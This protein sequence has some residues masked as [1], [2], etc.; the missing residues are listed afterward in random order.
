MPRLLYKAYNPLAP[1]TST[2]SIK[3]TEVGSG[4]S[5]QEYFQGT[6]DF[7]SSN[8]WVTLDLIYMK[9]SLLISKGW[10]SFVLKDISQ[11]NRH[12][13][14][15]LTYGYLPVMLLGLI[16]MVRFS[17]P[18]NRIIWLMAVSYTTIHIVLTIFKL[19]YRLL[20]EPMLIVYT[21]ILIQQST[22]L[23]K[24]RMNVATSNG[25]DEAAEME[26]ELGP[27]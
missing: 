19:R 9:A 10:D 16:G 18:E 22:M 25:K 2:F 8:K 14:N 24:E 26:K 17:N 5:A 20:I 23:W 12:I 21:G 1:K 27:A 11:S 15:I 6:M 7:I 13:T 4:A 3:E